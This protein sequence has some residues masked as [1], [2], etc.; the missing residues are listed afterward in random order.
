MYRVLEAALIEMCDLAIK[1][2]IH[3]ISIPMIATGLDRLKWTDV[4][5]IL[6]KTL[7]TIT[8]DYDL[9]ITVHRHDETKDKQCSTLKLPVTRVGKVTTS[10]LGCVDY[11]DLADNTDAWPCFRN[12]IRDTNDD[13]DNEE[14]T[15]PGINDNYTTIVCL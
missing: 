15:N 10:N 1:F 6:A 11:L 4:Y 3:D 2:N 9:T 13:E 7:N 5:Y 8:K 14:R 12:H